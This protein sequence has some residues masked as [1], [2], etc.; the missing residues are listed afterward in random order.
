MVK[1]GLSVC[2][3]YYVNELLRRQRLLYIIF[4]RWFSFYPLHFHYV[5]LKSEMT[6][7]FVTVTHWKQKPRQ[8]DLPLVECRD[9][10]L[11]K[12]FPLMKYYSESLLNTVIWMIQ[13]LLRV[14]LA[15]VWA[16]FYSNKAHT[17]RFWNRTYLTTTHHLL[18]LMACCFFG[19]ILKCDFMAVSTGL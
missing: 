4:I 19:L 15:S 18:Q 10:I 9:S 16:R 6:A 5:F 2:I 17:W 14:P 13:N 3:M 11:P 8:R 12:S 1:H 7:T